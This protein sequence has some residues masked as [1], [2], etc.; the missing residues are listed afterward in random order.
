[1]DELD[2]V[3][4]RRLLEMES[5]AKNLELQNESL[6]RRCQ[7]AESEM[8]ELLHSNSDLQEELA[9]A[10]R[11]YQQEKMATQTV[12]QTLTYTSRHKCLVTLS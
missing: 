7:H 6:T 4:S 3:T 11:Q 8:K 1:M 12:H 2:R 5:H 9:N 10:Q